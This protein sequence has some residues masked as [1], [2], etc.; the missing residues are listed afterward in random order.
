M[1]GAANHMS[2][3]FIL[4]NNLNLPILISMY[5]EKR[6]LGIN[7]FRCVGQESFVID[8]YFTNN[9]N[10]TILISITHTFQETQNVVYYTTN[11]NSIKFCCH[12]RISITNIHNFLKK[13]KMFYSVNHTQNLRRVLNPQPDCFH[14]YPHVLRKRNF[15][16]SI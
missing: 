6:Y 11:R 9:L 10:E 15:F 4:P 13:H 1:H 7:I 8:F 2:L 3:I 5:I 12:N 16:Y 14:E